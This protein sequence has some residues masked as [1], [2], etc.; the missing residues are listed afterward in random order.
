MRGRIWWGSITD[1]EVQLNLGGKRVKKE[2]NLGWS[3]GSPGAVEEW[4]E[5]GGA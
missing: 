3:P 4:W 5:K 2:E 1:T